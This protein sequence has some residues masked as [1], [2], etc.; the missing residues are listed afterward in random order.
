MLSKSSYECEPFL[1]PA[2]CVRG[3][4]CQEASPSNW[5]ASCELA[6]PQWQVAPNWSRP[7]S[8]SD[9]LELQWWCDLFLLCTHGL[10][11]DK[12]T[13]V[14]SFLLT[15]SNPWGK[16]NTKNPSLKIGRRAANKPI[17]IGSQLQTEA[18]HKVSPASS[19]CEDDV[20]CFSICVW[21]I[22]DLFIAPLNLE[23]F[24]MLLLSVD[25]YLISFAFTTH[26]SEGSNNG[27]LKLFV[28]STNY[29]CKH[30]NHCMHASIY[31]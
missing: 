29:I 27:Y 12:S 11:H 14:F 5:K 9:E 13:F 24:D 1:Q 15:L 6:R 10:D 16:Q 8:I 3:A 17:S 4:R 2:R 23:W 21:S 28:K 7:R 26:F 25:V 20:I 31:K 22:C 30:R 18:C 19:S